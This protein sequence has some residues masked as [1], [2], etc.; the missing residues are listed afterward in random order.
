MAHCTYEMYY[1]PVS[2]LVLWDVMSCGLKSD[3]KIK[4][5]CSSETLVST[6]KF[7]CRYNPEDQYV[8]VLFLNT[9]RASELTLEVVSSNPLTERRI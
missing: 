3:L 9:A 7:T 5:V 4:T 2:M 8:T 1:C 6:Y